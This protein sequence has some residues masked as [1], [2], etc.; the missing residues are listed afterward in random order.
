MRYDSW[1]AQQRGII[2][3]G[4][5]RVLETF[6]HL[7]FIS[8]YPDSGANWTGTHLHTDRG[9]TGLPCQREKQRRAVVFRWYSIHYQL[10]L[11]EK[12]V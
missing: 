12:Y 5:A 3:G 11:W 2:D 8:I 10:N 4:R 1:P 6:K 7:H 9:E